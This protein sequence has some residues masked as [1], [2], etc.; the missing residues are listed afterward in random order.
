[1]KRAIKN[2][3]NAVIIILVS[4]LALFVFLKAVHY[5]EPVAAIKLGLAPASKTPTLL[6]WHEIDAATAPIN[7]PVAPEK[8]PAEVMYK[9][10]STPWAKWLK[11]TDS[12]AF[13]VIRNG[14]LTYDWYKDGVSQ[15][16]QLPSYSVAKTL[17]S[18]MIGQLVSQGKIKES[19]L[20]V[21]Y[22]PELKTG[23]SF[24]MVTIKSL[25]DMR[26][27]VG[28]SDDYPSGPSGWGVAIAQMYATT[29]LDWFLKNNRKMS[30]DPG[31]KSEYR[32][33]DTQMLGMIIKKVTGIRISD[34]FSENVWKVVGAKYPATW[35]VDRIG[36]TEKTFCCF[37][38]AAIDYAKIGMLFLNGG[39]AGPN[40]IIDKNW[41]LRMATPVTKLDRG[42]GYGAQVWHPY[43]GI[44]MAL[45]LHGQFILI[46]PATRT[47]VV[48][49][50]DNPTDSD[51][52][53]DTAKVLLEISNL[54]G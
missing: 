8:M 35:N 22:F 43:P 50:S 33:V 24:D 53:S 12:N 34:Y 11:E 18:I 38:A 42:W 13:L 45:G 16:S 52:E 44:S 23:T 10:V 54:R 41:L 47:V 6:P 48:K 29:D 49:L 3:R 40:K 20:F 25:L 15:G 31:T 26:S 5:P 1:M 39:Y 27:G 2:L 19:D 14:V 17:T 9:Y 46:N 7:L 4:Y 51:H 21:D 28:V 30:F 32:S 37:N 36:G